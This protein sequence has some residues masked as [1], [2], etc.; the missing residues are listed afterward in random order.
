[1]PPSRNPFHPLG[2]PP[3]PTTRARSG[4]GVPHGPRIVI[5]DGHA[6]NP[7]DLSWEPIEKLGD[8][9]IYPRSTNTLVER[10]AREADIVL[11]NK[12]RFDRYRLRSLRHLRYIGVLA[13]GYDEVDVTAAAEQGV[14]V[15]NIPAYGTESVAHMVFAH[16]LNLSCGMAEHIQSVAQGDWIKAPDFCY[17]RTPL[18]EL[19]GKTMGIIGFGRIGQRVADIARAFGMNALIH[20]PTRRPAIGVRFGSLEDVFRESDAVSLHCPLTPQTKHLVNAKTLQLMKRT[21]F[22]IN[23]GRGRLIDENALARALRNGEIAGAGLDVL[24]TEPPTRD[25]PLLTA[26]RCYI[27]PHIAWATRES[28]QRLCRIAADNIR[29]FLDGTPINVVH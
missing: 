1:M 11:T 16:L 4:K 26:P 18:L 22:L 6:V 5:L 14:V 25:N 2:H 13:T 9:T 23:T 29:A 21:A 27:T 10:R 8:L 17:W 19:A 7:G 20:T 28:R 12:V 15:T 3:R 24:S